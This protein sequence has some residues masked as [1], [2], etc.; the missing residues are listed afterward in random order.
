MIDIH[1]QIVEG[2]STMNDIILTYAIFC[3]F[4]NNDVE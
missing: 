1:H 4:L 3:L 2:K